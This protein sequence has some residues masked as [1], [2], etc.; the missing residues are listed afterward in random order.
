MTYIT[1]PGGLRFPDH[2]HDCGPDYE[3]C[4]GKSEGQEHETCRALLRVRKELRILRWIGAAESRDR[5]KKQTGL[6]KWNGEVS[7]HTK[8]GGTYDNICV[9][10]AFSQ[11]I[12]PLFP[13]PSVRFVSSLP[14]RTEV[15]IGKSYNTEGAVDS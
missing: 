6:Q 15:P 4:E 3:T 13:M 2:Q 12:S 1:E 7:R 14:Y 10:D 9:L 11:R 8:T 5:G